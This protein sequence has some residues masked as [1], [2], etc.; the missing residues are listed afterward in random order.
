MFKTARVLQERECLFLMDMCKISHV[1]RPST[2][3]VI[4]KE[5]GSDSLDD[6]REPPQETGGN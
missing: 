1:L 4:G 5:H 2:E 3:A 6:L